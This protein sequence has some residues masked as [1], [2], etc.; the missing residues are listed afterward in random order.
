M[1]STTTFGPFV[2]DRERKQLTRHG[3]PV[4]VGHRGYLLLEALLDAE[5]EV[6]GKGGSGVVR[7]VTQGRRS[8][9]NWGRLALCGPPTPPPLLLPL[10][11]TLPQGG[12]TRR[13]PGARL[14]GS[15]ECYV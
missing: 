4:A 1:S 5:G 3:H 8:K 2:L 6:R 13:A 12:A 9:R 10:A 7:S 15:R 11:H 14:Q